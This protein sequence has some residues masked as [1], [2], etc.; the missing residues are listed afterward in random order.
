MIDIDYTKIYNSNTCGKFKILY[1]LPHRKSG[2]IYKRRVRIKFINTGTIKD[3]DLLVAINGK[4]NDPY[5]NSVCGVACLG[6]Y[7]NNKL[8]YKQIYDI[9]YHI[10]QRCYN[11]NS[12]S[13]KMY[14]EIGIRVDPSWLCYENFLNDLPNIKGFDL[15]IKEPNKFQL[16]KDYLQLN[17]PKS[18]RIYSKDTCC[19]LQYDTNTQIMSMENKYKT[20]SKYYGVYKTKYGTFQSSVMIN[21]KRHF[22]GTFKN[23]IDAAIAYNNA[24]LSYK[25]CN[26]NLN[27]IEAIKLVNK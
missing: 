13:Y 3:V 8:H 20:S 15:Y 22:I 25:N 11:N 16:D 14:G 6:N 2:T 23:E 4:V 18:N 7:K 1:E 9:W 10:I 19:F 27:M 17:I 26:N 12:N 24:V 5:Y 21:N